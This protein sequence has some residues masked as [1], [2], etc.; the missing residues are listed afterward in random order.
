MR[1]IALK[2]YGR[3]RRYAPLRLLR[4]RQVARARCQ[5]ISFQKSGRTWLRA[6]LDQLAIEIPFSHGDAAIAP[7]L[8]P[9]HDFERFA[10]RRIIFLHRDPRDVLVSWYFH[11]KNVL[12]LHEL[13]LG[14]FINLPRYG[15]EAICAY[16]RRWLDGAG[17]FDDFLAVTYEEMHA[18]PADTLAK[19]LHFCGFTDIAPARV[20]RAIAECSFARMKERERAGVMA[21]MFPGRFAESSTDDEAMKVRRGKVNGFVDY[22]DA[23]QIAH[24]TSVMRRHSLEE[25]YATERAQAP[26]G[27]DRVVQGS[28]APIPTASPR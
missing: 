18:A 15:I 14:E 1:G 20:E 23:E 19:V 6:M 25:T 21:A 24:C 26:S 22:L 10:D 5:V 8:D 4:K 3:L 27:S 13:P 9:R 11:T 12:R 28:V 2:A 16:N 17:R 7:Q